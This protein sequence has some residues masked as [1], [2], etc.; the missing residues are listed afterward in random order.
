MSSLLEPIPFL[1][2]VPNKATR[3]SLGLKAIISPMIVPGLRHV[4]NR[5]HLPFLHCRAG[6]VRGDLP[7]QLIIELKEPH[8]PM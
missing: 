3:W 6:I 5:L 7:N 4:L 2:V 1:S 8:L